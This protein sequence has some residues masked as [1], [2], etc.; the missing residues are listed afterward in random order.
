MDLSLGAQARGA[1]VGNLYGWALGVLNSTAP[2]TQP[3][4]LLTQADYHARIEVA[5]PNGL[6]GGR[7][8]IGLDSV[9]DAHYGTLR[10]AVALDLYLFWQDVNA[11]VLGYLSG[12]AG[13]AGKPSVADL[14]PALV[15]RLAPQRVRRRPGDKVYETVI[16]GRDYAFHALSRT[17]APRQCHGSMADALQAIGNAA[18]VTIAPEPAATGLLGQGL[19]IEAEQADAAGAG[20]TAAA[21]VEDIAGRL[22][23]GLRRDAPPLVLLREGVVHVGRRAIPFPGG[24]EPKVLDAGGGL[25][26]AVQDGE[27]TDHAPPGTTHWTLTCRGRPDIKP[28]DLVRFRK[29]PED[30]PITA[31]S[32][33]MA[34]AGAFS[35]GLAGIAGPIAEPPDTSL[36]VTD[37]T[38]RQSRSTGFVT[39]VAGVDLGENLPFDPWSLFLLPTAPAA[40]TAPGGGAPND[41]AAA[42]PAPP[43]PDAATAVARRMRD[44]AESQTARLRL[45]DVAEVRSAVAAT[46]SPPEPPAQT[47]TFWEGVDGA[48][49]QANAGR[50]LPIRRTEPWERRGAA[51]V[52]PF[53]WGACGLAVPRYPGMRVVVGYR[54]GRAEDPFDLGATWGPGERMQAQPG[55]WWLKLPVDQPTADLTDAQEHVPTGK[56]TNDLTDAAGTRVIEVGRLTIRVGTPL[57]DVAARPQANTQHTVS[58][59]HTDGKA[60]ISI[61]QNGVITLKGTTINIDAGSDGTVSINAKSVAVTV[62]QQMTVS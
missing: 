44:L 47:V 45:L 2:G 42:G 12:I 18:G 5:L 53:A 61:D 56:A 62:A 52:T 54:G 24:T 55:D 59:E 41:P 43:G 3:A 9:T 19:P 27:A 13:L 6:A 21:A 25:V 58:I 36:L 38:H 15:T 34:L 33:G 20:K 50:R 40:S 37:V 60:S 14:A 10:A 48:P 35:A 16:E 1:R 31:P 11:S 39:T 57:K 28:G 32:L 8:A 51:T 29:P 23:A 22:S 26:E 17:Q 46:A 7:V 4:L 30:V 49:G